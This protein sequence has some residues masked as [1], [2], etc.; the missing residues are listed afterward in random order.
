MAVE[1]TGLHSW[2]G[3]PKDAA[4]LL[5]VQGN[6]FGQI[7]PS[8]QLNAV[9]VLSPV[10]RKHCELKNIAP[11]I[12]DQNIARLGLGKPPGGLQHCAAKP[13][14]VVTVSQEE[15]FCRCN[16]PA[17]FDCF[18]P[19]LILRGHTDHRAREVTE[20]QANL[21][22]VPAPLFNPAPLRLL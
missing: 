1:Q 3:R 19:L 12:K 20:L 22:P 21:Q 14:I 2:R 17:S 10:T 9:P 15:E 5:S 4:K 8:T 6:R 11:F 13:I 16:H 7:S 18:E